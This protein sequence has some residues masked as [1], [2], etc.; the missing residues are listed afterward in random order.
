M[1]DRGEVVLIAVAAI[2]EGGKANRAVIEL[3]SRELGIPKTSISV[4]SGAT[5]RIK[6]LQIA[7]ENPGL[8]DRL[9]AWVAAL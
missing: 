9:T 4:Q 8:F 5:S 6:L 1:P 3:M 2:P 7:G